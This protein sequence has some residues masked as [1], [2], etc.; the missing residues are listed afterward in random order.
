MDS[1]EVAGQARNDIRTMD[2]WEIAGMLDL[3]QYR[4]DIKTM[5]L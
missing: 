1:W 4:N 2:S 5:D 3:I